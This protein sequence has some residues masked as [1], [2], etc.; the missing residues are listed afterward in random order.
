MGFAEGYSNKQDT[1]RLDRCV[2]EGVV[3][4]FV[5]VC[6]YRKVRQMSTE[7]G[8]KVSKHETRK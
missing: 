5:V 3:R 7:G 8:V 2:E 1:Y 6:M 4:L